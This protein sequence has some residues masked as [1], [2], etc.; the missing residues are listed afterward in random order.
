MIVAQVVWVF[1]RSVRVAVATGLALS[2]V[3]EFTFVLA[4]N[5]NRRGLVNAAD[6]EFLVAVSLVTLIA[7]PYVIGIAPRL[8]TALL[9]R[10]PARRRSGLELKTLRTGAT[11]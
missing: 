10:I 11:E 9:R 1:Q 7:T 6:L 5:G 4:D 2:Q 8:T 3:G